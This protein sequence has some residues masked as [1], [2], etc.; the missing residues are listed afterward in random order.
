MKCICREMKLNLNID[1]ILFLIV[2]KRKVDDNDPEPSTSTGLPTKMQSNYMHYLTWFY[3][4]IYRCLRLY[5]HLLFV[6]LYFLVVV[7]LERDVT[8]RYCS[9]FKPVYLTDQGIC[10]KC[11]QLL[12]MQ[13]SSSGSLLHLKRR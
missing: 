9:T 8:C 10:P 11:S 12:E 13:V 2:K 3:I 7:V 5:A 6:N 1:F 4:I